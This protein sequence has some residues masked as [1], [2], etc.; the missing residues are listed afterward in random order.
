MNN[1]YDI[2]C[3]HRGS[4]NEGLLLALL[5]TQKRYP[6]NRFWVTSGKRLEYDKNA[7]TLAWLENQET[8]WLV[9]TDEGMRFTADDVKALVEYAEEPCV[10]SGLWYHYSPEFGFYA[11]VFADKQWGKLKVDLEWQP[12]KHPTRVLG[13]GGGFVAIHRKVAEKIRDNDPDSD[14][15]FF[16]TGSHPVPFGTAYFEKFCKKVAE[17][18][19]PYWLL[20]QAEVTHYETIGMTG[21]TL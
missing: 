18:D 8:D 16:Q 7:I 11:G 1:N 5:D 15:P 12:P 20:P 17:N 13:T 10:T 4:I 9:W 21:D 19:F 2:A 3:I 6:W 14:Y